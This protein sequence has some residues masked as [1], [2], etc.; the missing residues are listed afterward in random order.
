[1]TQPTPNQQILAAVS[2]DEAAADGNLG[3]ASNKLTEDVPTKADNNQADTRL[4]LSRR[5]GSSTIHMQK[6]Y[7][8]QSI[9]ALRVY[10]VL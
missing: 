4:A 8:S 2:N 7:G 5:H 10:Q 6:G 3:A 9:Q 1:M